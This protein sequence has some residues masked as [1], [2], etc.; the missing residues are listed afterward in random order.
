VALLTLAARYAEFV[1]WMAQEAGDD[2]IALG[3]TR[4]AA[5]I[6]CTAGDQDLMA[7]TW[8]RQ[9]LVTLYAQDAAQTV[10]L[11][12]RAQDE[13]GVSARIRGLA[14]L[15]VAQGY[16]LGGDRN[17]CL[18]ALDQ[19]RELLAAA[20]HGDSR[21][22]NWPA[23]GPTSVADIGAVVTGWCLHDLGMPAQATEALSAEFARMP[24]TA[25]RAKTRYGTRLALAYLD[26]GEVDA[27]CSL[28]NQLLDEVEAVD[29]ATIRLDIARFAR[30][31]PRWR[32]HP[33]ARDLQARLP[34]VLRVPVR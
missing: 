1:G 23:L 32:S 29:S 24:G 10:E 9:A 16:A 12:K 22:R 18:R 34:A 5:E 33:P 20:A 4:V 8:V 26:A 2:R 7:H 30:S 17:A 27:A 13:S 14:A 19:G 21:S 15:R 11:A 3:W 25:R 28:L 31:L 6:A